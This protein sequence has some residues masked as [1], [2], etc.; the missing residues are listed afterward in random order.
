MGICHLR[1]Y[2]ILIM[3]IWN[4]IQTTSIAK[5]SNGGHK[6]WATVYRACNTEWFERV[7]QFVAVLPSNTQVH[8]LELGIVGSGRKNL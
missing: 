8:T 5:W 2:L 7:Y 6:Q 1:Y 4:T 3:N